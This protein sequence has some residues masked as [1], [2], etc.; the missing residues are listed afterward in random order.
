MPKLITNANR[1]INKPQPPFPLPANVCTSS[2]DQYVA[3][4]QV[5]PD[6]T[7][8]NVE[9]LTEKFK[10]QISDPI[11]QLNPSIEMGQY[12][13]IPVAELR[14]MLDDS[15]DDPEFI[16]ICSALR[17]TTNSMGEFKTFPVSI[18]VPVKKTVVNGSDTYAVCKNQDSVYIES[19][20]CPPSPGC[21]TSGRL[22]DGIFKAA[23]TFNDFNTLF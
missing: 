4:R 5:L 8:E 21:P 17:D 23:T 13:V 19:Y 9:A 10:A 12:F 14:Q 15:G 1:V 7:N 22:T 3:Q 16:H 6:V 18:L 20:P 11:H 2:Y